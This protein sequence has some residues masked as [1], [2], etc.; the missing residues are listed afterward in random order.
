MI[1]EPIDHLNERL[2]EIGRALKTAYRNDLDREDIDKLV[3]HYNHYWISIQL[4][5]SHHDIDYDFSRLFLSQ[6]RIQYRIS[7]I[8]NH[9]KELYRMDKKSKQKNIWK[10]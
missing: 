1:T 2:H 5:A 3:A 6:N 10:H 8:R 4:L 7:R 9:M